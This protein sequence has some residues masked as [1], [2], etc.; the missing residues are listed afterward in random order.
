MNEEGF[1]LKPGIYSMPF[2][3]IEILI[4]IKLKEK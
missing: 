2:G 1:V 3:R 4:E